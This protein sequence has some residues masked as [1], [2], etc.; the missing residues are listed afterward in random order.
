MNHSRRFWALVARYEPQW[1]ELDR[2]LT[3][4]WSQVPGWVLAGLRG[5]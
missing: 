3:A 4:G 1:R 2:E 5:V